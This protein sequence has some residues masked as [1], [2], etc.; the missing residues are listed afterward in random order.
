MFILYFKEIETVK[1]EDKKENSFDSDEDILFRGIATP[2]PVKNITENITETIQQ[3]SEDIILPAQL[4]CQE[5]MF[6]S[7][8]DNMFE[9]IIDNSSIKK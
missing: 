1:V 5:E 6:D 7:D 9:G 8:D 4:T 3:R 2:P